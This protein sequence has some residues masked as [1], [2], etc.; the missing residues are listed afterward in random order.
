MHGLRLISIEWRDQFFIRMINVELYEIGE[1]LHARW[2]SDKLR[3]IFVDIHL[4]NCHGRVVVRGMIVE[5]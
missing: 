1:A 2:H 4:Q 3:H 5:P